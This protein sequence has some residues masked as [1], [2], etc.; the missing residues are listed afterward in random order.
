MDERVRWTDL[1]VQEIVTSLQVDHEIKVSKSV[2]RKLLKKHNYRRRKAQ[3]M[4]LKGRVAV[5]TGGSR[6]IGRA[7]ALAL[8][9]EGAA[10]AIN[11]Q[12]N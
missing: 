3:K 11:Y 1:T 4:R 8:A 7:M 12:R 5:V 10:V 9:E 6:G 2:V